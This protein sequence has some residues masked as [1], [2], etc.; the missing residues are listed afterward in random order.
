MF[1][2][3]AQC[4]F[5]KVFY[6]SVTISLI[7]PALMEIKM[8]NCSMEMIHGLFFNYMSVQA[9]GMHRVYEQQN[10][11]RK[12][13]VDTVFSSTSKNIGQIVGHFMKISYRNPKNKDS[14]YGTFI[15]SNPFCH[16]IIQR[17]MSTFIWVASSYQF[18]GSN[19]N[20]KDS[21]QCL[22][23]SGWRFASDLPA[24]KT[25]SGGETNHLN[26]WHF[27]SSLSQSNKSSWWVGASENK[28]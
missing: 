26:H 10:V 22:M 27:G 21:N 17:I 28:Y 15:L 24:K 19:S 9:F 14:C 16:I 18:W 7:Q 11:S 2:W 6:G 25:S 1:L 4:L 12:K 23:V 3:I 20:R 13:L 8:F 5:E